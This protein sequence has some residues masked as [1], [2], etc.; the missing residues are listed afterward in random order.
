[1]NRMDTSWI[2]RTG[3]R[4]F[5]AVEPVFLANDYGAAGDGV[6]LNTGAIQA[7][8][9]AASASGGGKVT[10][11]PGTYLSGTIRLKNNVNLELPKGTVLAG[12]E[13]PQDYPEIFTRHAGIELNTIA[14]LILLD[15]CRCAAVTGHGIIDGRG[16]R[17]W[18]LFWNRMLPEYEKKGLR[19]CVDYDCRRP[20][21]LVVQNSE[22]ITVR[23]VTF[24]RS[25]HWTVH[26][27]YSSHVTAENIE[28]RNNI[29]GRGP[30]TDGFDID[31]SEYIRVSRCLV[32][33][34]DDNF[35]L[36]SGRDADGLRVNRPCRFVLIENCRALSGSGLVTVGSE[37]SGGF[38]RILVRDCSCRNTEVGI[39]FKSTSRRG[40]V[41]RNLFFEKI[42]MESPRIAL[43]M[44][45]D[46]FPAYGSCILPPEF[47]NKP[48]PLHWD[49]LLTPVIPPER[50]IPVLEKIFFRQIRAENAGTCC[51]ISGSPVIQP[52]DLHFSEV[53]LQ[54]F[55]GGSVTYA[56]AETVNG[57]FIQADEKPLF[58]HAPALERG[59]D[60][61]QM[62][63]LAEMSCQTANPSL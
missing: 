30:S 50:G 36:K 18:D 35:C 10:F 29:G 28:I 63:R 62:P 54:G 19:W 58:D 22:D 15:H 44:D 61:V 12:S 46:W 20:K 60:L 33:C 1:M 37:T 53:F 17:W 23:D 59:I 16:K 45:L 49:T 9:D 25:A 47:L 43:E 48:H 27:L 26:I 38:D 42:E 2:S 11:A 56:H 4:C 3:A 51:R 32:S 31:S 55:K 41:I 52:R 40:G 34:N 24:H 13:N 5:P 14:P 6:T 8:V 57:F 21:A 7:A 39:R